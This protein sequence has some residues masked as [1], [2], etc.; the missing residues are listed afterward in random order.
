MTKRPDRVVLLLVLLIIFGGAATGLTFAPCYATLCPEDFFSFESRIHVAIFYGMLGAVILLLL[1]GSSFRAVE[2]SGNLTLISSLPLIHKRVTLGGLTVVVWIACATMAT[3][4]M[5]L[6]AHWRYWGERTDPLNW[7]SAKI[8]LTVTGVT[9]HYAD[10][11]LG[12]SIVPVSRNSL[13]GHAFGVHQSTLL[14]AHKLATYMCT[15]AVLAHGV[16][17]GIFALN[18]SKD[19]D[20]AKLQLFSNG[21]PTMTELESH[22][23][24]AWY[25]TVTYTGVGTFVC[26]LMIVVTALPRFRRLHY[27]TF[28]NAHIV[29]SVVT[30]VGASIHASSDF[31][32]LLPGLSL[33]V[34][35]WA[36]R[37]F[38]G[39]GGSL[40]TQAA[41]LE[42]AGSGWYR[43]SLGARA[44]FE[45]DSASEAESSAPAEGWPLAL[46][47][48][49]IPSVSRLQSHA[50]T[51]AV[52]STSQSGPVFLF[53]RSQGKKSQKALEKEWTW[54]VGSLVGSAGLQ[55]QLGVRI[56][57]PYQPTDTGLALWWLK[58]RSM[59]GDTKF[60]LVWTVRERESVNVQE[61]FDLV[62][63]AESRTNITVSA[64]VSA[65]M[66]RLDPLAF[67]RQSL[68]LG[69]GMVT[70][71]REKGAV[72]TGTAWVY[73]SGP[74]GLLQ[75]TQ[76]ACQA[77]DKDVRR[78]V[79]DQA[80]V[81]VRDISW[82]I[83]KWEV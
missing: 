2:R 62:K 66:G 46:Y 35:D 73:S 38:R 28:Y 60:S 33:W 80:P 13:L 44:K 59:A 23:R 9:G 48:L 56:E 83:A 3:T 49:S 18:P 67:I 61:W 5:W 30:F 53:R 16:G 78:L 42:N 68:G 7:M 24:S 15:L 82:Y 54:A 70:D 64:H 27:N 41:V 4:A 43:V 65:E 76:K 39:E 1:L 57:G 37:L 63:T 31:Y 17:Y 22:K 45:L 75:A 6:P 20:E 55:R 26:M 71:G 32:L 40:R 47:Y 25:G 36:W 69:L 14:Y 79:R 51:A 19:E 29:C 77:T 11:L 81:S 58:T 72:S 10:I 50:F 52:S 21:N 34:A 8:A 74:G 12:L